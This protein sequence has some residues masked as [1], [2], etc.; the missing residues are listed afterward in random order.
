MVRSVRIFR[1]LLPLLFLGFLAVLAVNYT[2]GRRPERAVSEPVTSTIR[3]DDSP[4]LVAYTFEDVQTIGG[5]TV[6][7]IKAVRTVGFTSGWYTLE[8]VALTMFQE[9]GGTYQL[10]AP[11]AQFHQAT[12]EARADGGV[13]ITSSDGIEIVTDS[14]AFDGNRLVNQVP[15]RFSAD[16]WAGRAGGVDF[17]LGSEQLRLLGGVEA[18]M[19]PTQTS[20]PA[21]I[22][23]DSATFDR[24]GNEAVFRGG[25]VID[26]AG[27]VLKT[28]SI[29]ARVDQEK[30]V[31]TGLEGCCGVEFVMSAGS[32]VAAGSGVGQTVVI[33]QRFFTE[34]SPEGEMRAIF[35]EGGE[36][37]AAA[38]MAGPP[39]RNVTAE[40]FRVAF[41][42]G[43]V[44]ELE[45][46]GS[47]VLEEGAPTPRRIS[48]SKVVTY[49]DAGRSRPT[50]AM[51]EGN[52]EYR[53]GRNRASSQRATF[54]FIADRLVL[55]SV[56]GALPA[57]ESDA[58][59]LTAQEIRVTPR[60]GVLEA[61][62][63]V[64]AR[65]ESGRGSEAR[66]GIFPESKSPVYVN[67]EKLTLQQQEN[68]ARFSGNVRAW[69]DQN[70]ILAKEMRIEDQGATLAATGGVRAVLYN[71]DRE[72][73]VPINASGSTLT[74]RRGDREAVL[75]GDVRIEDVGRVLTAGRSRFLFDAS[76]KLDRVE[77]TD[78]V[79]VTENATRRKG[80]GE[81][82]VYALTARTIQLTGSP[83]TVTDPQGTV[84]GSEI[85]FDL[86]RNKV[87]V[88]R[89]EG[90]TEATYVPRVN[91]QR[92]EERK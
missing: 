46:A 63:F 36:G 57:V 17:N 51:A 24:P 90:Q 69:Q 37:K 13:R 4:Q 33:G 75:E 77:A 47:A 22:R 64:K 92:R 85:V 91:D 29:T 89:G 87:E 32:E 50:S 20:P 52:V 25:V 7:Q 79:T 81:R 26:R 11:Q 15:V 56:P 49:F 6:S 80:T 83:A 2:R 66:A 42:G 8:Q 45:A 82:L 71:A 59:R 35:V 68:S 74:A 67:S 3:Q 58:H 1:I 72:S 41:A 44:A 28:E 14:I 48:A 31:L 12:K 70:L 19:R 23:S 34:F 38:K 78:E 55:A 21:T 39:A 16:Q 43:G 62:G 54:D 30:N 84:K 88:L 76:Q 40:R 18:T 53:D 10:M 73:N 60:T 86:A 65:L 9:D 27:D 61:E 5:R